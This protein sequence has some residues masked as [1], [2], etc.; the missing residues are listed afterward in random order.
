MELEI[1]PTPLNRIGANP[2]LIKGGL[3]QMLSVEPYL[4]EK[5]NPR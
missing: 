4:Q 2:V 5:E 3:P 1:P